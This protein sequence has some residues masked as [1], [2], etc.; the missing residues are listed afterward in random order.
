M[1][2][3]TLGN[4]AKSSFKSDMPKVRGLMSDFFSPKCELKDEMWTDYLTI[5]IRSV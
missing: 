3:S 2:K 5:L 1:D 4:Y